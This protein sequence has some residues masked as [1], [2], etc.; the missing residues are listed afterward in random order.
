MPDRMTPQPAR[1]GTE[2]L[3]RDQ[4]QNPALGVKSLFTGVTAIFTCSRDVPQ[5]QR[6]DES[7]LGV[8]T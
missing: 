4:D 3:I 8:D 2:S 7:I 5:I 6:V 1:V